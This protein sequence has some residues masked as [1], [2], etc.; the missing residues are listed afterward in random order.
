MFGS[1]AKKAGSL[2]KVFLETYIRKVQTGSR[3]LRGF[4]D[5]LHGTIAV[6]YENK[7]WKK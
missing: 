1:T 5:I 3:V 7:L 4:L 6:R 2:E